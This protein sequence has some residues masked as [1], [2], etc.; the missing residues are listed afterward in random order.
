MGSGRSR[1][2]G[3]LAFLL[4]QFLEISLGQFLPEGDASVRSYAKLMRHGL[5]IIE[6]DSA[7]ESDGGTAAIAGN[8]NPFG[9][10]FPLGHQQAAL[11]QEAVERLRRGHQR[12]AKNV[13]FQILRLLAV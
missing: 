1:L 4:L 9:G 12:E 2:F 10:C 7:R 8:G 5:G 6:S 13:P 3:L 11:T